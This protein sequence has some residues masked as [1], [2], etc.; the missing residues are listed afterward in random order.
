MSFGVVMK[1]ERI[2]PNQTFDMAG[3]SAATHWPRLSHQFLV[4]NTND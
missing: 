2:R 3:A 4:R 1:T